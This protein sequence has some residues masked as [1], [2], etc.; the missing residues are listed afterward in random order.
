MSVMFVSLGVDL[1]S[2]STPEGIDKIQKI[3]VVV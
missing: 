2:A 3:M 1:S